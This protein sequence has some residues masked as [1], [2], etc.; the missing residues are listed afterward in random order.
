MRGKACDKL[1]LQYVGEKLA[2][3]YCEQRLSQETVA[4][5]ALGWGRTGLELHCEKG[6]TGWETHW[7]GTAQDCSCTGR[8]LHWEDVLL[9]TGISLKLHHLNH[10]ANLQDHPLWG[11]TPKKEKTCP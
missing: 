8:E 2:Q 9:L 5:A 6:C 4:G 11:G 3:R 10:V 1:M 7:A